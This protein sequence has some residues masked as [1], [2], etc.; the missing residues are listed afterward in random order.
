M[1]IA[2]DNAANRELLGKLCGIFDCTCDYA[3]NGAEAVDKV[4]AGRFDLILMDVMMPV[5]D[6][7]DATRAIRAMPGSAGRTPILAVTANGR[8]E[9]VQLC[10]AAGVN[11]VV[12]KP[13]SPAALQSAMQAA[14]GE[15]NV[16]QPD[17]PLHA[18][19][20]AAA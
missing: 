18:H 17:T 12:E 13:I 10:Y 6:G 16:D 3:N 15:G 4:R 9:S 7:N 20:V 11:G 14:L 19:G 8:D 2:D 1:L 5:M